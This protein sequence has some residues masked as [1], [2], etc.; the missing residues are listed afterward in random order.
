MKTYAK[1]VVTACGALQSNALRGT[2]G[3]TMAEIEKVITYTLHNVDINQLRLIYKALKYV[4]IDTIKESE[5]KDMLL[6]R[7]RKEFDYGR[8]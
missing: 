6:K 8:E 4:E 3:L 2:G 5:D 7:I 1:I